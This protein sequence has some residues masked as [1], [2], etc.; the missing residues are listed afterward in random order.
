MGSRANKS[1]TENQILTEANT[2]AS[3]GYEE[4]I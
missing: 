3:N 4:L 1:N 2:T